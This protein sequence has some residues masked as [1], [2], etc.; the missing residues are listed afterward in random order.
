MPPDLASIS[1]LNK[2][3][4]PVELSRMAHFKGPDGRVAHQ[5]RR[6]N[7]ADVKTNVSRSWHFGHSK[8]RSSRPSS[9]VVTLTSLI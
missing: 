6:S 8:V 3:H 2:S 1:Y 7:V 5:A 9:A 4:S